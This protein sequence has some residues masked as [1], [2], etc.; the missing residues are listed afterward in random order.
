MAAHPA[1]PPLYLQPPDIL[2][3]AQQHQQQ[4]NIQ[5]QPPPPT[6]TPSPPPQPVVLPGIEEEYGPLIGQHGLPPEG[7]QQQQLPHYYGTTF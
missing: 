2:D 4:Q 5:Q 1:T 6:P 3:P 7:Q